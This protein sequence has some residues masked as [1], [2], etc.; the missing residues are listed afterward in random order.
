MSDE[1]KL[2]P[3]HHSQNNDPINPE[4]WE[5]PR[6]RRAAI[7]SVV[8]ILVAIIILA[9]IGFALERMLIK[10]DTFPLDEDTL[11][12]PEEAQSSQK[13][14]V[15][16]AVE[17]VEPVDDGEPEPVPLDL[18]LNLLALSQGQEWFSELDV[19]SLPL[20]QAESS[21]EVVNRVVELIGEIDVAPELQQAHAFLTEF[22][23]H[24]Q[25]ALVYHF[26]FA[27]RGLESDATLMYASID[28]A[29]KAE[30]AYIESLINFF[31]TENYIYE[32]SV[33]QDGLRSVEWDYISDQE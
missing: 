22:A 19:E 2:R 25:A 1:N 24:K 13:I 18:H 17:K 7:I 33:A 30:T 16:V 29:A 32:I 15:P 5:R 20:D 28:S 23:K 8:K 10:K 11:P 26:H 14:K 6:R 31:E 3:D 9:C 4:E 12:T 21:T 27:Q